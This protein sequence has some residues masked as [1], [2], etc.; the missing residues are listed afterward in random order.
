MMIATLFVTVKIP[1][2]E[3][4]EVTT[5]ELSQPKDVVLRAR[6]EVRRT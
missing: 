1:V 3:T 2:C 4:I 6:V 5:M